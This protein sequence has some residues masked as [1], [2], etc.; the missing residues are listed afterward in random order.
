MRDLRWNYSPRSSVVLLVRLP[1]PSVFSVYT[2]VPTLPSTNSTFIAPRRPST[3]LEVTFVRYGCG[4][5][6]TLFS[7]GSIG[8]TVP[9]K[10]IPVAGGSLSRFSLTQNNVS[11][12]LS[13]ALPRWREVHSPGGNGSFVVRL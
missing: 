3:A 6:C 4:S 11:R 10:F 8:G 7:R 12:P 5:S 1:V 9:L 2:A 13:F